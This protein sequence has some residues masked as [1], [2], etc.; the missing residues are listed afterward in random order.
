MSRIS[1]LLAVSWVASSCGA[2]E[3]PGRSGAAPS[4]RSEPSYGG[5]LIYALSGETYS[6]FPGR[7]PGS[8]AQDA[9]LYALEG[10]VEID[11]DNEIRPWLAT[12]W[13]FSEDGRDATF[14]LREGVT[15]HDGTPFD[16]EAVAF[17]FN[18]ALAK[19]FVYVHLLEGLREVTADDAHTVTFRFEEPF[20]ALLSNLSHRSL[21]IFSPTAYREHGEDWMAFNL[22]GTGPFRQDELVRGEYLTLTRNES[23]WQEG[24][25]YLDRVTIRIVPEVSARTAMLEAGEIDRT[26]A[27]NDFDVP[28][29]MADERIRVRVVPSTRQF[30]VALNHTVA[31]LDDARVRRAFNYAVDKEGI[32]QSVFAGTG[33]LLSKA[34]VLSEG[35][36]AFAD[37]REPG[38]ATIFPYDPDRARRLL[39]EAGLVDRD[40][41]GV[42]ESA[43]GAPLELTLFARRG[44]TKGDDKIAQLLQSMLAEVG[45]TVEIRF[46]ESSAFGAATNLGPDDAQYD[47]VLLSWGIPTAD[48][49]EPMM[50]MTYSKAWKPIGANRMFYASE[51]V[52]RLTVSAHHEV[53][54]ERRRE[55]VRLWMEE[56]LE[57]APVV[58]L[59]TLSLTLATRTYV[60]G[61]R[62]L[63]IDQ[64]PARF[65]WID[66]DE[67]ARQGVVR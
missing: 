22:V 64:Y 48:P 36:V 43:D 17:V 54:P 26:I 37:M 14:H 27:L 38:D 9:W 21:V 31:P 62:I 51:E 50:M 13:E 49:D 44:A 39:A 3:A 18:E 58:F 11:E 59:P 40:G 61:D 34:P 66:A 16:A 19:R 47:M 1:L 52:D 23:Y 7:Q 6:L 20:A 24:K 56:L 12:D 8:N 33:A 30:Y 67:M 29:L 60:H 53:D 4:A 5:E 10:L 28:R 35:V 65:A 25:P 41:D 55:L 57:D 45:V 32:V 46:W 42:V 2:P 15:F 63:G